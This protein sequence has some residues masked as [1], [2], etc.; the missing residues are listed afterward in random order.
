M[1]LTCKY[2]RRKKCKDGKIRNLITYYL[3]G[4]QICKLKD[5]FDNNW[6]P[7]FGCQTLFS[8]ERIEGNR[9]RMTRTKDGKSRKVSYPISLK[10]FPQGIPSEP[11]YLQ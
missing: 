7:D 1:I 9:L 11:I 5:P 4:H 2:Q 6:E 8:E 10:M 3:D